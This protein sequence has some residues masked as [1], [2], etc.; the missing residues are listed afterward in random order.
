[1][2]GLDVFCI[3]DFVMGSLKKEYEKGLFEIG[4]ERTTLRDDSQTLLSSHKIIWPAAQRIRA[5]H[6]HDG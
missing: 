6:Q 4:E 1:M 2:L 5:W 3:R